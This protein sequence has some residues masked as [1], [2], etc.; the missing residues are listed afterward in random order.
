M[1]ITNGMVADNTLRNI[2][3]A[4]NAAV[5][6][7]QKIQRASDDP[8]VATRAVTYRSYVSQIEQYQG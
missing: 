8:V 6:S 7:N 3:K 5:S 2:N 1:R 4:A